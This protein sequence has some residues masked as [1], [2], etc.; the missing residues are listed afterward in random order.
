MK[1]KKLIMALIV[2]LVAIIG[3]TAVAC[4]PHEEPTPESHPELG[5]YY[6]DTSTG[7][8]LL[9]L[10][11]GGAVS[12]YDGTNTKFGTY[13]LDGEKLTLTFGEEVKDATYKNDQ[14]TVTI[15]TTEL[16]KFDKTS[17]SE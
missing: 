6:C 10:S 8:N 13:E 16:A 3:M 17:L 11:E 14:I 1:A 15:G 12:L 7:E 4:N 2:V 9:I 5:T